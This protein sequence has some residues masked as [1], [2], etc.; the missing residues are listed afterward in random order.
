ME[1]WR[2]DFEYEAG[3]DI[4][5]HWQLSG[6]W[7]SVSNSYHSA[8]H[9]VYNGGTVGGSALSLTQ[10]DGVDI[11][12]YPEASLEWWHRYDWD[13]EVFTNA[14]VRVQSGGSW[15]T[16]WSYLFYEHA[17][18]LSQDVQMSAPLG[19][20]AGGI[21]KLKFT[22]D[23][24]S[25]FCDYADWWID[26]LTITTPNDVEPPWF[27]NSTVL[28]DTEDEGPYSV[29]TTLSDWHGVDS[30][31]LVWRADGGLWNTVDM[32]ESS[33]TWSASI[34]SQ[35]GGI[36]VEYYFEATDGWAIPNTG[37][38]PVGAP[39]DAPFSFEVLLATTADV[40]GDGIV[41]VDDLLALVSAWGVCE[42]CPEDIDHNGVVDVDDVLYLL[43]RFG[44]S[45]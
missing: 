34:P 21:V 23:A 28:E 43:S 27:T 2:E 1:L 37:R 40:N 13:Q 39:D 42:G 4:S 9:A 10:I 17:N 12:E 20:Y 30:A 11:S 25:F 41:D 8:T 14:D 19:V 44:T 31:R 35:E 38:L 6:D 7:D 15:N 26:D 18:P 45:G 16:I 33:G 32:N 3:D 36:I 22:Y 24:E 5:N 29:S